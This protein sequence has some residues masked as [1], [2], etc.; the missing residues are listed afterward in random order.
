MKIQF[1]SFLPSSLI[2]TQEQN[3]LLSALIIRRTVC[4]C[5]HVRGRRRDFI[6]LCVCNGRYLI[7][8][9]F[10][11]V[12]LVLLMILLGMCWAEMFFKFVS[13][14]G[15]IRFE[16]M[17]VRRYFRMSLEAKPLPNNAFARYNFL[18]FAFKNWTLCVF[19]GGMFR[20]FQRRKYLV[21]ARLI[22]IIRETANSR[23][24]GRQNAW[25]SY[26]QSSR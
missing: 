12:M 8:F 26:I 7:I 2:L 18:K 21:R 11:V 24:S 17:F 1:G 3:L 9:F 5:Q 23:K 15:A 14:Q 13:M 22:T 19:I 25:I 20:C 6:M 10:I 16:S 4:S